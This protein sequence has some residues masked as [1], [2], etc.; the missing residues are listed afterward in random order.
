MT[1]EMLNT[2]SFSSFIASGIMFLIAVALFFL[3]DIPKVVGEV[4]GKTAK[5]SIQQIQKHNEGDSERIL[6]SSSNSNVTRPGKSGRMGVGTEKIA[7][8]QKLDPSN[9]TTLLASNQNAVAAS[10]ETTVLTSNETTLLTNNI[11]GM[12]NK[13][14]V[15]SGVSAE[16]KV[17]ETL[18][19]YLGDELIE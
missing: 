18:S 11:I 9:E 17:V 13:P 12:E 14:P 6:H 2:L 3:L 16:C 1:V 10:N 8:K 5:K 15:S 4:S 7:G 19:S